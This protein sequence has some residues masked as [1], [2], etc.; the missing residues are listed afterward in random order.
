VPDVYTARAGLVYAVLPSQG[1]SVSLGGRLDG[2]PLR[3]IVGGG[4]LGFRRPGFI[5]Y[6]DHGVALGR[7]RDEFTLSAPIRLRQDFRQSLIDRQQGFH[8]GGDLADLL[9]FPGYTHR[10]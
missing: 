4:E 1:L 10:F 7:G 3:D 9:V 5:F 2:I 8:G 6:L